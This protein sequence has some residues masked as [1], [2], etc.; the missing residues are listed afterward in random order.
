MF[1][2][3]TTHRHRWLIVAAVVTAL[4]LGLYAWLAVRQPTGPAAG[5]GPQMAATA[6]AHIGPALSVAQFNIRRGRG[7]DGDVDLWRTA[8]CLTGIDVAGLNEV[9]GG[10]VFGLGENQAFRLADRLDLAAVFAPTEWR[11]GHAHFGNGLLSALP[12][13]GWVRVPLLH[14]GSTAR[15]N[16]LVAR[17]LYEGVPVTVLVA[18]V[19]RVADRERQLPALLELFLAAPPPAILMGDMNTTADH[20]AILAI[21][22][23]PDVVVSNGNLPGLPPRPDSVD[24]IMARGFEAVGAS[25]CDVGASD[26]PRV[27][28]ELVPGGPVGPAGPAGPAGDAATGPRAVPAP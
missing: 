20:P 1:Q 25:V 26:H 14:A 5:I 22:T 19:D 7:A 6:P 10:A 21:L 9:G 3:L 13:L 18:H 16:V 23:R 17:L 27:A 12:V 2:R 11:F 8:A 24:W 15:R 4:V 28:L